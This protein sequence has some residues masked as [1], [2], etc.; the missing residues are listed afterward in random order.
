MN[1]TSKYEKKTCIEC[2]GTLD[3]NSDDE[4]VITVENKDDITQY[5]VNDLLK[6]MCGSIV[7]FKSENHED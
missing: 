6:E 1:L 5:R 3:K 2:S 7:S 4:Y